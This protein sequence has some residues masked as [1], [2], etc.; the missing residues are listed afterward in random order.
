MKD[1]EVMIV[2]GWSFI[3]IDQT[4]HKFFAD[5]KCCLYS[6][7]IYEVLSHLGKKVEEFSGDKDSF[8]ICNLNQ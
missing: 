4:I 5:D 1:R 2:S 8:F 3:E 7:E 6:G